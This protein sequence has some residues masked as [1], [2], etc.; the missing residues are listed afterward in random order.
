MDW[1]KS[2]REITKIDVDNLLNKTMDKFYQ[3]R[4]DV[5][6]TQIEELK[7]EIKRLEFKCDTPKKYKLGQVVNGYTVYEINYLDQS[8]VNCNWF[9]TP[10]WEYK[11]INKQ[12]ETLVL[13]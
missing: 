3:N 2:Y 1:F 7:K 10:S 12:G 8:F 11:G 5:L 13:K 9:N 4:V 6:M